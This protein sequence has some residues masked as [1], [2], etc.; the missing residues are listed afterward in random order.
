MESCKPE[1]VNEQLCVDLSKKTTRLSNELGGAKGIRD[2]DKSDFSGVVR[3]KALIGGRS[4]DNGRSI[5]GV[6]SLKEF[7]CKVEQQNGEK[8][9][10]LLGSRKE[11]VPFSSLIF[12]NLIFFQFLIYI[13]WKLRQQ[14]E[15]SLVQDREAGK[16]SY[17]DSTTGSLTAETAHPTTKPQAVCAHARTRTTGNKDSLSV[18]PG[19]TCMGEG[20]GK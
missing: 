15:K 7:F 3:I 10:E 14:E 6:S 1:R 19:H 2:L 20:A 4:R 16:G 8:L 5:N 9:E 12:F 11:V 13:L 17:Q 18:H